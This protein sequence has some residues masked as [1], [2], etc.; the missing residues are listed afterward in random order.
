MKESVR[1]HLSACDDGSRE[2][3]HG[4]AEDPVNPR[5]RPANF[6]GG[7]AL[8]PRTVPARLKLPKTQRRD[9]P[10]SASKKGDPTL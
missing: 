8:Y 6:R 4:N 5:A 9:P 2:R 1:A 10:G 3:M 7:L